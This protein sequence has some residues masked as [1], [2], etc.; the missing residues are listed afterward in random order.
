MPPSARDRGGRAGFA[1]ELVLAGR[2]WWGGAIRPVEIG[3]G[4]EGE[5]LAVGRSVSGP[6]RRDLGERLLLPAA[7]DVHVHFR[8]PGGPEEPES[9][10]SGTRQAALG[11]VG[12]VADMPNTRP[13]VTEV[14]VL[15]AKRARARGRIAVDLL[16]FAAATAPRRVPAL[17][18]E[19]G[20]FKLYLS[21]TTGIED[22]PPPEELR[23]LLEAVA[24]TGLLLTVHAEDPRRFAPSGS[25]PPEDLRAWDRQRPMASELL[26]VERLLADAPAAL[27]LNVAHLTGAGSAER[28]RAAG[29]SAEATPH[30]LLLSARG[31]SDPREKVNP[32]LRP[33]ADRAGLW[34]SFAAGEVPIL[35]SDHAPHSETAKSLPFDR[36]PS[37]VPGVETMLPLLLE[38]VRTGALALPV[39]LRAA[40]D[41]PARL[42]GLPVGRLAPGHRAHLIAIDVRSRRAIRARELQAPCGWTPFEGRTA[43]FPEEHYRAG[44]RIVA[45]GEFVGDLSAR[46]VRPEYAPGAVAGTTAPR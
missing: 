22:V 19:A 42:L 5:I 9:F 24:A 45:G 44:E 7:T 20:A 2:T 35:A 15:E 14:D 26:A 18:R 37:G 8:D 10:E 34:R 12:T 31:R 39:L 27:R 29:V 1:P 30:H 28:I 3:I 13:P 4:A 16:L 38:Q 41:R 40:C 21:P 25:P 43:I 46:V 6:R 36:A 23:P 33:E 32:P 17:A 11:G